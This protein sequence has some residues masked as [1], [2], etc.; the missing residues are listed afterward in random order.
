MKYRIT[1]YSYWRTGSGLGGQS[2]DNI[3]LKDENRLPIIP[4]KTLKG[5]IRDA[6]EECGYQDSDEIF[7]H[8]IWDDEDKEYEKE[9]KDLKNGKFYFK[10]ARLAGETASHLL[11]NRELIKELYRTVTHVQL[12]EDKQALEHALVK[13]E[14]CIPLTLEA[15]IIPIEN[16]IIRKE[17]KIPDDIASRLQKALK[18]LKNIG[19][20]RYRGFGRCEITVIE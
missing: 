9:H 11:N 3:V 14:V 20:K 4:G 2:K 12:D 18:M 19:E 1:F 7:G 16:G 5:L 17:D 8:G 15:E 6:Y 10:S 13:N